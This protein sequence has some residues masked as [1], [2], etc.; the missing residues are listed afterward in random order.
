MTGRSQLHTKNTR[1]QCKITP[2]CN[3]RNKMLST[4]NY[5]PIQN[6]IHKAAGLNEPCRPRLP[7]GSTGHPQDTQQYARDYSTYVL[8]FI[9]TLRKSNR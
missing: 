3:Y 2:T 5:F 1:H 4:S 7:S 9:Y 8:W 6:P